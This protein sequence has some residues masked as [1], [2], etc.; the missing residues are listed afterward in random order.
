MLNGLMANALGTRINL[1]VGQMVPLPATPDMLN[2]LEQVEVKHSDEEQSAFQLIFN[3]N[4]SGTVLMDYPLLANQ[5]LKPGARVIMTVFTGVTPNVL[6]DG[7]ITNQEVQP[8]Q[9]DQPGKLTLTGLDVSVM[10]DR[11][12]RDKEHPAQIENIIVS[13]ILLTYAQYG[14]IPDVRMPPAVEFTLPTEHI[15]KQRGTDLAYIRDLA[16][17]HGYV[18]F[19]EPGPVPGVNRGYW[20]PPPR[21]GAPQPPLNVDLGGMTNTGQVNFQNDALEPTT[22]SGPVQDR[23]GNQQQQVQT[24]TT[25][26]EP[27]ATNQS[28]QNQQLVGQQ[29]TRTEGGLTAS[30]AQQQAQSRTDES[31]DSLT[32][33]GELDSASYGSLLKARGIVPLRGVGFTYDGLYYVKNVTHKIS[34]GSYKQ[35]F[36]LKRE[37][38][39]STINMIPPSLF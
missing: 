9:G 20:G 10:M 8:A 21:G 28:H 13:K 14:I 29:L 11:E 15:P 17:R 3:L 26:R 39:G 38:T 25:T 32:V 37:G 33:T 2:A 6:M 18:F 35:S 22:V 23:N 12:E 36:T 27:L 34:R 31:A 5:S 19:I 7:I 30:Q 16:E 1:L 24:F 4:R